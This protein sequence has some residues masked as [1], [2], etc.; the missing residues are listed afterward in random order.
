MIEGLCEL[1][2]TREIFGR[3]AAKM[4]TFCPSSLKNRLVLIGIVGDRFLLRADL[5]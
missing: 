3:L 5:L 2:M 1:V 4:S